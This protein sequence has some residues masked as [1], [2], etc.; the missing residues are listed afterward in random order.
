MKRKILLVCLALFICLQ[1]N[2]HAQDANT[3][4]PTLIP[5]SSAQGIKI[6]Q[7]SKYK[8]DFFHLANQFEAQDNSMYCGPTT[9]AI[10]LNTLNI[11]NLRIK[12]VNVV[13]DTISI[14]INERKYFPADYD[15]FLNRFT[16]SNVFDSSYSTANKDNKI[17]SKLELL[18]QPIDGKKDVGMQIRQLDTLFKAHG[19]HSEIRIVSDKMG[20]EEVR[21]EI[22]S[23][24]SKPGNYVVVNYKRAALGQEGH[25]HI[26]PVGAYDKKTDTLLVMDVN[27]SKADWVW[28]KTSDLI[29]AMRTLDTVENRGYLLI[30]K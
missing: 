11:D 3:P 24:L 14:S 7:D 17:K 20:V 1:V 2:V 6:F 28:V 10:I 22:I 19:L 21:Q 4:T 26:S 25:G 18:G 16:Q 12:K 15:P 13:K 9:A 5:F 8:V 23:N 30:S 27:P 29:A